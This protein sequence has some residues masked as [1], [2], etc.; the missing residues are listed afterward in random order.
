L[1]QVAQPIE[2]NKALP[3]E[4]DCAGTCCPLSTTGPVGGAARNGMKLANAETSS[5]TAAFGVNLG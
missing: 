2:P 4:I 1:W 5:R 3:F